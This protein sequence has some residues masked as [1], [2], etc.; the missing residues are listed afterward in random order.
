LDVK[1]RGV[2]SGRRAEETLKTLT[3]VV[4]SDRRQLHRIPRFNQ[5]SI[6]VQITHA[7]FGVAAIH[8]QALRMAK[9]L[10][11]LQYA[12]EGI[13]SILTLGSTARAVVAG[14][15]DVDG[16]SRRSTAAIGRLASPADGGEIRRLTG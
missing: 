3:R 2:H 1:N 7:T 13:A 6:P 16:P 14:V 8:R 10:A 4:R 9:R 12:R 5:K 11:V 15:S